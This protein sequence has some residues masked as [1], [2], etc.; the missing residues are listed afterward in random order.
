MVNRGVIVTVMI[1]S[2]LAGS[3][4]AQSVDGTPPK[5]A[6][7]EIKQARAG[8]MKPYQAIVETMVEESS[9]QHKNEAIKRADII[10]DVEEQSFSIVE[11]SLPEGAL[12]TTLPYADELRSHLIFVSTAMPEPD[13]KAVLEVASDRPDVHIVFRGVPKEGGVDGF[14][15]R[16][17]VLSEGLDRP[18]PMTIDPPLWQ[19]YKITVVPTIVT[20]VEGIEIGRATGTSNP[21]WMDEQ[22]ATRKGDLG[23]YGEVVLPSEPDMEDVLRE[24][25]ASI[26]EEA[27]K[28]KLE[29]S[30]WHT[31]V[32]ASLP[33]VTEARQR[34]V[35]PS[36]EISRDVVLPDGRVLA[37]Q[38]DRINPLLAVPFGQRLIV[39]DASDPNQRAMAKRLARDAGALRVVVMTTQTPDPDGD[40]FDTWDKW[41]NDIEQTLF[42]LKPEMKTALQVTR[43]PTM[44]E[45]DGDRLV[46]DEMLIEERG[47]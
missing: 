16:L 40:G 4:W 25:V 26:D 9:E 43:V 33:A 23:R 2:L 5:A 31:Q 22:L 12:Q 44:I 47:H 20:L 10:H 35:D 19:Q 28:R 36:V 45:A 1:A 14:M 3:V 15:Q 24:A 34:R 41:Q 11:E 13:L 27:Y 32:A 18:A 42:L 8:A 29:Q 6:V 46:L 30:F 39:I 38:G 7:D 37:K 17:R 21:V